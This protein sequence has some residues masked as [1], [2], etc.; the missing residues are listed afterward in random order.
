M[1]DGAVSRDLLEAAHHPRAMN[2]KHD[3]RTRTLV[4]AGLMHT[5]THAYQMALIPLYLPIQQFYGRAK[6][7]DATLLV[8]AMLVAYFLPSYPMGMLADRCS[9]KQLLTW[10]LVINALGFVGLAFAP[11]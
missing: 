6:I 8:T 11:N 3:H 4:L 7:E 5:F 10:G 9:R 1:D 2:H